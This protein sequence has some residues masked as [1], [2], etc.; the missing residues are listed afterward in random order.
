MSPR[1]EYY[2][3]HSTFPFLY[4]RI[5][6]SFSHHLNPV[7]VQF[8]HCFSEISCI[9]LLL[10][11][12]ATLIHLL[13]SA[14]F[15]SS[16]HKEWS[17]SAFSHDIE[18]EFFQIVILHQL[19][20]FYSPIFVQIGVRLE[21]LLTCHGPGRVGLSDW[22]LH[23]NKN[24]AE[25][26][27]R[28]ADMCLLGRIKKGKGGHSQGR[29]WILSLRRGRACPSC[30]PAL[31]GVP[32]KISSSCPVSPLD[33]WWTVGLPQ[34]SKFPLCMFLPCRGEIFKLESLWPSLTCCNWKLFLQIMAG[35][36]YSK[37][38]EFWNLVLLLWSTNF[39]KFYL[40]IT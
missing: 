11:Q 9:V 24:I 38:P 8:S 37:L 28:G 14:C 13:L 26:F 40:K 12:D 5:V 35:R 22:F 39:P 2:L 31:L 25:M 20:C 4:L 27:L 21:F 29:G 32:W 19:T 33:G 36:N 6:V 16:F 1:S 34:I 15:S 10:F 23:H 3:S 17:P 18:Q 30:P 7:S